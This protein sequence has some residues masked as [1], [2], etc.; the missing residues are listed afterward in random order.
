MAISGI[1]DI[2]VIIKYYSHSTD[3]GLTKVLDVSRM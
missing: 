1:K 3:E 2:N